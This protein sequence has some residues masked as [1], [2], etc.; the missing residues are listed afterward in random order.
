MFEHVV[1]AA[2]FA[3]ASSPLLASLEELRARGARE[4]TLVDVL[5]SHHVEE[6]SADHRE[7]THRRLE[8][9][10]TVLEEAGFKVNLEVR[11]GQPAHEFAHLARLR[12]ASLILVGSRGE[13]YF[14]EF[15]RGSTILQ[16]IR[17][18]SVPTLIEPIEGES[19]QVRGRGFDH[20][21]LATDFSGTAAD[22]EQMA[23]DLAGQARRLVLVHVME[24]D[25]VDAFGEEGAR[26][27]A[28]STMQAL[29]D[30][31][32]N[33]QQPPVVRIVEGTASSE[34]RRIAEDEGS[35][36]IIM[37]KRGHSPI[38]EL[39]LGSTIQNVVRYAN[40]SVLMVPH[41]SGLD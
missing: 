15:M 22:A 3:S 37:G 33:M 36:M 32:P 17:K 25:E 21:L 1:V 26:E 40:C 19:R 6:Q 11:T 12:G 29:V 14:R 10:R 30:R 35:S 2:H 31:L 13:Q 41:R 28:Q 23:V 8:E 38:R 5:R 39:L 20:L 34:I 16:L 9:Q 7:E 24:D 18:T 27:R 4:L